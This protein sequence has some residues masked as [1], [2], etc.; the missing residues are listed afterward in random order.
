MLKKRSQF[1]LTA[2]FFLDLVLVSLCWVASVLLVHHVDPR[3]VTLNPAGYQ[4]PYFIVLPLVALVT[5][6][7]FWHAGLYRPRRTGTFLTEL[8]DVVRAIIVIVIVLVALPFFLP[9][10]TPSHE[11]LEQDNIREMSRWVVALFAVSSLVL[12]GAA[13]GIIRKALW[14]A[15]EH[16]RNLR[17]VLVVGAGKLGQQVVE[18]IHRNPWTGFSVVGYVDDNPERQGKTFLDAPVLGTAEDLSRIIREKCVD[19]VFV[20]LPFSETHKLKHVTDLLATETVDL[21]VVPD[22]TGLVSLNTQITNFDG[23]PVVSI[24]ESPLHGW[25]AVVKRVFDVV[26]SVVAI[27]ILA[28]PMAVIALLVKLSS[29]GPAFYAQERMGLD[30]RLFHMSKFRT[31]RTDAEK[32]TGAVWAQRDD[33]RRTRLGTF[34]RKT[35]LDEVPQFFNVLVGHMSIVGP[36]PE[37]PVFIEQFKESVPRYMLRHKM[38]A[39]ITGWAQVNGWRGNTSLEKR[40]QYDLYYIEN[41]SLWLDIR[42]IFLTV[43]SRKTY[44]DAY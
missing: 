42:I 10:P 6:I 12:V 38:K 34:L 5:A 27:V 31:M 9:R 20:A 11:M 35:S 23:L 39:G 18:R 33:P 40:I 8:G 14:E 26:V 43:F 2:L 13:R 3:K 7:S 36:R 41:W 17:Y 21:R 22:L 28:I 1:F 25:N 15:R 4:S 37:R 16:G 30:G 44:Q 29:R 19:Q 24:R 32:Q